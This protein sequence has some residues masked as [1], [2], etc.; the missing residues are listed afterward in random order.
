M[1]YDL[2]VVGGGIG[3]SALA[4]VMAGAGSKVLLLEASEIYEDRVRGEWISPWGVTEVKRLGLYDLLVGAGGHHIETHISYDENRTPEEARSTPAPLGVFA[5]GVPGPLCLGHPHHCQTLFNEALGRGVDARR[6][7]QVI[8]VAAGARP[9]VTFRHEGQDSTVTARLLVGADGRAS[10]VRETLGISLHQDTPHHMFAGLLVEGAPGWDD[11]VQAIGVEGDFSFLAFPQGSGRVRLYGSY[12]LDQR[13][14]F[15]G[16]EGP[17]AFLEAFRMECS[18]DNAHLADANPL[19]DVGEKD[20]TAHLNFT[21]IALAAQEAGLDVLGYCSQARFL[22][23]CG[24]LELLENASFQDK[25]MAQKLIAEHEMGELFKVIGFEKRGALPDSLEPW[26]PLGFAAGALPRVTLRHDPPGRAAVLLGQRLPVP[27]VRDHHVIV[28]Q[29]IK[30]VVRRVTVVGLE[31]DVAGFGGWFDEFGQ[32]EERDACEF[33]VELAPGRDAVEV[34]GVRELRQRH[35]LR[36][37]QRQRVLDHAVNLQLP[38]VERHL[39]LDAEIKRREICHQ[40]LAR[41]QTIRRADLTRG[42]AGQLL[43]PA[44]FGGDV[45]GF[46]DRGKSYRA[47]NYFL[48]IE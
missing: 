20:I 21:G 38:L 48:K 18:P 44:L 25:A 4:A 46:H 34:A 29:R 33:H 1:D 9:T 32:R 26:R 22:M 16:P 5:P 27:R 6:G 47:R 10:M 13:R 43:G 42:L 36:P 37:V 30:R 19:A 28:Q 7:V 8:S 11:K 14:R 24:L 17:T 15:S 35:E 45:G 31:I 3:G 39:G 41:R 2:I 23:N 40:A 12:G